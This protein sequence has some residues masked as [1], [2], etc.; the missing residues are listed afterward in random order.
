MLFVREGIRRMG[1]VGNAKDLFD[2]CD[3]SKYITK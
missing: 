3:T 1:V 2:I